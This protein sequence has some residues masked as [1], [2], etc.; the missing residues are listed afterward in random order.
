[1]DNS[2]Q[3]YE[4]AVI[5]AKTAKGGEVATATSGFKIAD[6]QGEYFGISLVQDLVRYPDGREARIVS[7]AG[8]AARIG[9]V[10]MAILGSAIEGG[11]TIVSNPFITECYFHID[12]NKPLPAGFLE[13]NYTFS[14]SNEGWK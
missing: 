5:G 12:K 1:M 11:D 14:P 2:V 7:G 9:N 8:F 10:P 4:F 13:E 6:K 3:T